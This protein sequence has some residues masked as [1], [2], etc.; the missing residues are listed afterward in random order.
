MKPT[1]PS[2]IHECQDGT[3]EWFDII[4]VDA[5]PWPICEKF[6]LH[7]QIEL[8]QQIQPGTQLELQL[9]VITPGFGNLT[10]PCLGFGSCTYDLET[11]LGEMHEDDKEICKNVM[12]DGQECVLPLN[13][14]L[15]NTHGI[16]SFP[17]ELQIFAVNFC[18][19]FRIW[20]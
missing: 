9:T 12:P 11:L 4:S 16:G 20:H 15:Y 18:F 5:D 7:F 19:I 1:E 3:N 2:K 10:I 14:G 6:A 17:S 13:T 8:L